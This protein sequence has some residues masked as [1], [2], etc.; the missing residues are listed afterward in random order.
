M[1]VEEIK[2]EGEDGEAKSKNRE[3]KELGGSGEWLVTGG[4]Q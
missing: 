2:P 3:T 4:E 1:R